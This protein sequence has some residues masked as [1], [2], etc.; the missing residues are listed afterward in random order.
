MTIRKSGLGGI[1]AQ[2][3]PNPISLSAWVIW[4]EDL[5]NDALV[6]AGQLGGSQTGARAI[7]S[8]APTTR[9]TRVGL[10]LRVSAP[11][12]RQDGREAAI[13][14]DVRHQ[15]AIPVEIGIERRIAITQGG[16]NAFALLAATGVTDRPLARHM[17]VTGYAQ[18]GMV[19]LR[20][21]SGFADG[22]VSVDYRTTPATSLGVGVWAAAQPGVTRI[23]VGPQAIWRI[24]RGAANIRAVASWRLRVAG[25]AAPASGPALS[26]GTDF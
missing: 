26:I 4:R 7:I 25:R 21:K 18:A 14:F 8:L 2:Q 11:L 5:G 12:D 23:D 13:G 10:T 17:G 19:G 9:S 3:R 22:A 20:T 16:R 1:A 6:P 15:G 24:K